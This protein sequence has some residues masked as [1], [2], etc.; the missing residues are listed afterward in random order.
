VFAALV[1]ASAGARG[2]SAELAVPPLRAR[3]TDLADLLTA[4]QQQALEEKLAAFERET[5]HQVA[6]L[7][8]PSLEGEPIEQYSIRV[9]DAWKLGRAD[10]DNGALLLVS[11][12]DRRVRIEVGYGLEGVIPDAIASRIVRDVILPRFRRGEMAEGISAGVDAILAAA[13]GEA[14]PAPPAGGAGGR[15][16]DDV[17]SLALLGA[18]VGGMFGSVVGR[19]RRPLGALTGAGLAGG[20]TW[21]LASSLGAA[22]LAAVLGGVFGAAGPIGGR[23]RGLFFPGGFGGGGFGG[24]GFGGGGFSGGGGGFGGGGASGS[25]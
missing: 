11:S 6:V 5:T 1:V 23:G 14:V 16:P 7:T 13:R 20:I 4:P 24:G 3:V 2:A 19:R 18:F 22:A 8:V 9:V 10:V 17:F 12:G 21:L 25:W 15:G